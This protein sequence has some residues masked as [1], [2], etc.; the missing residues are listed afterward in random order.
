VALKIANDTQPPNGVKTDTRTHSD[1]CVAL[2]S[3]CVRRHLSRWRKLADPHQR[4]AAGLAPGAP[5]LAR[6]R[7]CHE[8]H[9]N[10][11]QSSAAE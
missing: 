6:C 4:S 3:K 8:F 5:I 2:P 11:S 1:G 7:S 10:T 9:A